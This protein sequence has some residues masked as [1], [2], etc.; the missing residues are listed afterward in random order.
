MTRGYALLAYPVRWNV[1]GQRTFVVGPDGKIMKKDLGFRTEQIG[2]EM[3][4][5][6]PDQTWPWIEHPDL[7]GENSRQNW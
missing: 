6:N 1:S 4:E 2:E 5:I 7:G 3:T